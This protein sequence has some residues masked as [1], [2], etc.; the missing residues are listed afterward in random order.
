MLCKYKDL[1]C[2]RAFR[3]ENAPRGKLD[4]DRRAAFIECPDRFLVGT[5]TYTGERWHYMA[6]HANWS[7][8]WLT[9]LPREVAERIAYRNGDALFTRRIKP[10]GR[11][12]T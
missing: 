11:T 2:D 1:R 10:W 6:E 5:D 4:A 12:A 9:E 8:G 7:R 3:S